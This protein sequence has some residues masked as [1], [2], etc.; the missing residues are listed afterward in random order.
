MSLSG[1][2]GWER[3]AGSR[4]R[5][6]ASGPRPLPSDYRR[7]ELTETWREVPATV[8]S[9]A[10]IKPSYIWTVHIV[11]IISNS[12]V[13]TY[14]RRVNLYIIPVKMLQL[15]SDEILVLRSIKSSFWNLFWYPFDYKYFIMYLYACYA[16]FVGIK[17]VGIN[18]CW[19]ILW[20]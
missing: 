18:Y 17:V 2:F 15:L 9:P 14:R 3:R 5:G 7:E 11:W 8:S 16:S 19:L 10:T 1:E 13:E 12:K 6:R 20:R 4:G